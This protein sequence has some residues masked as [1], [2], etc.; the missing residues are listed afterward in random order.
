MRSLIIDALSD[1]VFRRPASR[2]IQWRYGLRHRGG[3]S[4]S[5]S[6]RYR[7][8]AQLRL[9]FR[10]VQLPGR[11]NAG[12]DCKGEHGY[13]KSRGIALF[14]GELSRFVVELDGC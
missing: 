5:S 2:L 8:F 11:G 4:N 12:S 14:H 6:D 13:R 7:R 9:R 1:H 3:G 10:L